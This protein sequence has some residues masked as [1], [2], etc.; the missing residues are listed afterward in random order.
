MTLL[1]IRRNPI[2]RQRRARRLKRLVDIVDGGRELAADAGGAVHGDGICVRVR[3]AGAGG[4]AVFAAPDGH[5]DAFVAVECPLGFAVA[6]LAGVEGGGEG[7][8]GGEEEG[9]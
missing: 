8:G 3:G 6:V 9:E 5:L 2:S 7:Q 1:P 4:H